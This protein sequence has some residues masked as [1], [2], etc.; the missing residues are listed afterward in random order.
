[1]ARRLRAGQDGCVH[2]GRTFAEKLNRAGGAPACKA[3]IN[4]AIRQYG[5]LGV[6]AF[7]LG[8]V[9]FCLSTAMYTAYAR[10]K[11]AS[12]MVPQDW[13]G[14]RADDFAAL[15]TGFGEGL[16]AQDR[17]PRPLDVYEKLAMQAGGNR[18]PI[19]L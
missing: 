1:M 10:G 9:I 7:V 12:K 13:L 17:L 18:G 11:V 6:A 14:S 4:A 19:K 3:R 2:G 16:R 5:M 15:R 8:I